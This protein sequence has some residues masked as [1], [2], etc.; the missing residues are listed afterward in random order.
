MRMYAEQ[1]A[2]D[3]ETQA[4]SAAEAMEASERERAVI[5]DEGVRQAPMLRTPA[6]AAR[7]TGM[8]G[9]TLDSEGDHTIFQIEADDDEEG[10]DGRSKGSGPQRSKGRP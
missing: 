9:E 6:P 1:T 3:E 7:G 10:D 8:R 5:G 2:K 4:R